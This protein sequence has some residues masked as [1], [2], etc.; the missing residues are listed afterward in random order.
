M[1]RHLE[2]SEPEAH[3]QP[4]KGVSPISDSESTEVFKTPI[5]H[6]ESGTDLQLGY[7]SFAV[8]NLLKDSFSDDDLTDLVYDHFRPVYHKFSTGMSQTLKRQELID[9]CDKHNQYDKLITLVRES[10]PSQYQKYESELIKPITELA[11]ID[12]SK[13]TQVQLTINFDLSNFTET[14]QLTIISALAL[15]LR[16]PRDQIHRVNVRSG[17][18]IFTVEM[19]IN[20]AE[21]LEFL[22]NKHDPELKDL[23][24]TKVK[25][26]VLY[27]DPYSLSLLILSVLVATTSLTYQQ[28]DQVSDSEKYIQKRLRHLAR[29]LYE[30]ANLLTLFRKFLRENDALQNEFQLGSTKI[31]VN[32]VDLTTIDQIS[33]K[34]LR[35][36][37][38]FLKVLNNLMF[39]LN[40]PE[41]EQF[42][43]VMTEVEALL[44]DAVLTS[45]YQQLLSKLKDAIS[46]IFEFTYEMGKVY[47]KDPVRFAKLFKSPSIFEDWEDIKPASELIW[48][49]P[50]V[51]HIAAGLGHPIA[52]ENIKG[53][54]EVERGERKDDVNYFAV[55]VEGDS[56]TGDDI[57]RGDLVLIRQQENVENGD[58]AAV[59]IITPEKEMSLGV[60]KRY[61]VVHEKREDL[62]HWL[63]ESSNPSSEHLVVIPT[64]VDIKAIED[65]YI[66]KAKAGKIVPP[67]FYRDAEIAIAGKYVGVTRKN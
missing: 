50:I 23:G 46:H 39:Y 65:L 17:S 58:I 49:I 64:G 30:T 18:V 15:I 6:Q 11:Q 24:V 29:L 2:N 13:T 16:I 20:S 43:I 9:Y 42:I 1:L 51:S 61:Y 26:L 52:E 59:V 57:F 22:Y 19:P 36:S 28:Y 40:S 66:K 34:A 25:V 67:V 44:K 4:L 38:L 12:P 60:L 33:S 45:N 55:F 27:F 8:R 5:A 21:H 7:D 63:L 31:L 3:G 35:V 54:V 10:N 41:D 56:M 37:R 32:K 47:E 14:V 48:R 53:Y 62:Q